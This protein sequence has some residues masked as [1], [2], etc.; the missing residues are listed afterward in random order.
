MRCGAIIRSIDSSSYHFQVNLGTFGVFF[1][2]PKK[3]A[4]CWQDLSQ[5]IDDAIKSISDECYLQLDRCET[6][7]WSNFAGI[8]PEIGWS[9]STNSTSCWNTGSFIGLMVKHVNSTKTSWS[10]PGCWKFLKVTLPLREEEFFWKDPGDL[11]SWTPR[12]RNIGRFKNLT[13]WGFKVWDPVAFSCF[14]KNMSSVSK[15]F[16]SQLKKYDTVDGRNPSKKI[17]FELVQDFFHQ[18]YHRQKHQKT[19]KKSSQT[20]PFRR[21][22]VV[23]K[24]CLDH[25]DED[26]WY[27]FKLWEVPL[28]EHEG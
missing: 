21:L 25:P 23:S 13:H 20:L 11:S 27:F 5:K 2:T 16:L 17:W 24:E 15:S 18:Q 7:G 6:S 22:S 28:K 26:P 12:V 14:E 4:G 8:F 3:A 1:S 10:H 9:D 19:F